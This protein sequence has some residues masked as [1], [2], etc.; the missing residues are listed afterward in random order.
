[1]Y[2]IHSNY[3]SYPTFSWSFPLSIYH[4]ILLF[5]FSFTSLPHLA[6]FPLSPFSL[7]P[8]LFPFSLPHYSQDEK[9]VLYRLL[10]RRDAEKCECVQ[11]SPICQ[12]NHFTCI[13]KTRNHDES[14]PVLLGNRCQEESR[15]EWKTSKRAHKSFKMDRKSESISINIRLSTRITCFM[16]S[17][18]R[19]IPIHAY[20]MYVIACASGISIFIT[21]FFR[22]AITSC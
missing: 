7:F 11:G 2:F 8:S 3:K 20:L 6:F 18:K 14:S 4:F 10:K 16:Y 15:G 22:N 17:V 21:A 12:C 9:A 19:A 5:P 1:M 13:Q